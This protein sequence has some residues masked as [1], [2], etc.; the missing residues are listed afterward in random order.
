MK[1]YYISPIIRFNQLTH[2]HEI[3]VTSLQKW[4]DIEADQDEKV[5]A[6]NRDSDWDN[7]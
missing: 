7:W 4:D 3:I 6:P 1:K 2:H 5:L